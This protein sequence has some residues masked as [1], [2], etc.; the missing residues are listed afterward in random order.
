MDMVKLRV[1]KES[2]TTIRL[3]RILLTFFEDTELLPAPEPPLNRAIVL[4]DA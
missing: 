1:S 3:L 4:L 2:M